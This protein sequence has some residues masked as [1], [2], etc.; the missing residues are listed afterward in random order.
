MS[1]DH[2]GERMQD[3]ALGRIFLKCSTKKCPTQ[4]GPPPP[5]PPSQ[6]RSPPPD[7]DARNDNVQ[8]WDDTNDTIATPENFHDD[9][10]PPIDGTSM[11]ARR[12]SHLTRT[13]LIKFYRLRRKER[14]A[15]ICC[16]RQRAIRQAAFDRSP[17]PLH[18]TRRAS[19][20]AMNALL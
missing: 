4:D 18:L 11:P 6:P 8:S 7:D 13:R 15:Y 16:A 3:T 12:M 1:E 17:W 14:P 19:E 9:D 5:M 10:A 2:T 20:Q